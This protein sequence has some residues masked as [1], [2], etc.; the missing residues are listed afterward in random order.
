LGMEVSYNIDFLIKYCSL[1]SNK[2]LTRRQQVV[3]KEF[4]KR[5]ISDLNDILDNE[6]NLNMRNRT[7]NLLEQFKKLQAQLEADKGTNIDFYGM[8]S[9]LHTLAIYL[10]NSAKS[11]PRHAKASDSAVTLLLDFL[12]EKTTTI[13]KSFGREV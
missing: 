13:W 7:E 5:A 4:V 9:N 8:E 11:D 12:G 10:F 1:I 2:N 3:S 6:E